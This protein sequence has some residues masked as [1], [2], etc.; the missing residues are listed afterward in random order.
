[1]Y[2]KINKYWDDCHWEDSLL[3]TVP[4][5]RACHIKWGHTGKHWG[6]WQA[7]GRRNCERVFIMVSTG[8]NM[9]ARVNVLRLAG[10]NNFSGLWDI[11]TV[12]SCLVA[13][14]GMF[15]AV[16]VRKPNQGSEWEYRLWILYL[17]QLYLNGTPS[18]GGHFLGGGAAREAWCQDK[19]TQAYYWVG[20]NAFPFCACTVDVKASILKKLEI[21]LIKLA[22]WVWICYSWQ[23]IP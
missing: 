2:S 20:H 8:M 21:R 16:I 22:Q 5:K 13:G 19:V 23:A 6:W 1:M 18:E 9:W 10:L 3:L 12:S 11:G 4:T 7:E 14:H 15:R 17:D